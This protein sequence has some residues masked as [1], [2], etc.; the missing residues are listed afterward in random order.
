MLI[1]LQISASG[2]GRIVTLE[3]TSGEQ[4]AA[5][6]RRA[7]PA[8]ELVRPGLWSIPVPLPTQGLRYVL[9][10]AFAMDDGVTLIDVGWDDDAAWAALT[11]GLAAIGFSVRDVIW[12]FPTH[13]HRD[14]YG[15]AA[16]L[17]QAAGTRI[18]L[19]PL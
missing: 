6:R 8:V 3:P 7:L 4:W 15:L 12:A 9:V 13:V 10:Y 19:H 14:H 11:G 18:G 2:Q 17:Q 5:W 1:C 16:R